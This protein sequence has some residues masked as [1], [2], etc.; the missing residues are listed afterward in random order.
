MNI[1]QIQPEDSLQIAEIY[2][3]Y[4]ENSHSTF[5]TEAITVE[6]MR[7]RIGEITKKYPFFVV[8]ENGEIFGYAYANQYKSRCAY[9]SSVEVSVYVRNGCGGRGIGAKLYEKLIAEILQ[10]EVHAVIAGI[11]LPNEASIKLHERFDFE[12]VAHFREVGFKFGKWIDVGYWEL[13]NR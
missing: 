9:S 12:K 7:K 5:E 11:S 13:L 8:E 3:Y 6:E 10:T 4:I 1:R 2:N